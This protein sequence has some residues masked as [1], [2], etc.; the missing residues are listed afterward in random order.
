MGAL[1][2]LVPAEEFLTRL[3]DLRAA[4]AVP[5]GSFTFI[6]LV[7][8]DYALQLPWSTAM[9]LSEGGPGPAV[10]V[11]PTASLI[12][13]QHRPETTLNDRVVISTSLAAAA[14]ELAD[15]IEARRSME[16]CP[17]EIYD[18][19]DLEGLL[20]TN[21]LILLGHGRRDSGLGG[22]ADFLPLSSRVVPR[23]VILLGCW[24]AHTVQDLSHR[25]VEGLAVSLLAAGA[26]TV[27]ASLWPVA[28]PVGCVFVAT[29]LEALAA[30]TSPAA[31]FAVARDTVRAHYPHPAIWS[32]FTCFG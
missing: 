5:E 8:E 24:S 32:G 15:A 2:R 26:E 25:E 1:T 14:F 11:T 28:V 27:V 7:A 10:S 18:Q 13:R 20:E 21:V 29:F 19:S 3:A 23:T 6:R 31:A 16:A 30:D 4:L 22:F 12:G 9:A 17:V